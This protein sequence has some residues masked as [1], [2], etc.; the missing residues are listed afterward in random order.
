MYKILL[1]KGLLSSKGD[2][3]DFLEHME[4]MVEN[5]QIGKTKVKMDV[6]MV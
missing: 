2:V 3:K 4:F 5:Y 6:K 1:P